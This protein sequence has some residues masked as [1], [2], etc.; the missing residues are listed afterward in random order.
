MIVQPLTNFTVNTLFE[1]RRLI[2][3]RHFLF[4][5]CCY[6][7]VSASRNLLCYQS[8][9]CSCAFK[10][11]NSATVA[12]PCR[13]S[14]LCFQWQFIFQSLAHYLIVQSRAN[15]T[16]Y[17]HSESRR[18]IFFLP[19]FIT[20][21]CFMIAEW[22]ISILSTYVTAHLSRSPCRWL[23]KLDASNTCFFV[24]TVSTFCP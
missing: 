13:S 8:V 1:R 21:C 15:S 18:L 14:T 3:P 11:K 2:F 7:L 6:F 9:A 22:S 17:T 10:R 12:I 24:V 19:I 16:G 4:N 20:C 23:V 5:T